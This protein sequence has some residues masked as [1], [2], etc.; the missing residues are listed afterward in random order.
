MQSKAL[1]SFEQSNTFLTNYIKNL[2]LL[3]ALIFILGTILLNQKIKIRRLINDNLS[4]KKQLDKLMTRKMTKPTCDNINLN[5]SS[6]NT[7]TL[8]PLILDIIT[9]TE[10]ISTKKILGLVSDKFTKNTLNSLLYK[11][12]NR[13]LIRRIQ[14]KPPVWS[15]K[16]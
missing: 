12:E 2:D 4:L 7:N 5:L 10:S 15:I 16:Q 3:Y 1:M 6:N 11:M 13:N 9:N 14:V 8:E